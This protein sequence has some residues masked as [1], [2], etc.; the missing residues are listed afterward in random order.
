[1]VTV[2]EGAYLLSCLCFAGS[3]WLFAREFVRVSDSSFDADDT[4]GVS[5]GFDE[6]TMDVPSTSEQGFAGATEGDDGE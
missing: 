6:A 1:M 4:P 3:V 5:P 2:G